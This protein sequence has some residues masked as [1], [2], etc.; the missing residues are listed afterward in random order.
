MCPRAR[1]SI[2]DYQIIRLVILDQRGRNR[3]R[4]AEPLPRFQSSSGTNVPRMRHMG[5]GRCGVHEI[6]SPHLVA[7]SFGVSP[8]HPQR[9]QEKLDNRFGGT[10]LVPILAISNLAV[11]LN[12]VGH[13]APTTPRIWHHDVHTGL[14]RQT[15]QERSSGDGVEIANRRFTN[16]RASP[17]Q[18]PPGL[19]SALELQNIGTVPVRSYLGNVAALFPV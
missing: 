3:C 10:F 12:L 18:E 16:I 2:E 13:I 6:L 14:C 5:Q 15:S 7:S 17:G 4:S 11:N 19:G 9:K 1:I 8:P